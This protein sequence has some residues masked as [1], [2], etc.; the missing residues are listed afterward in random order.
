MAARKKPGVPNATSGD[1]DS[2]VSS[3][4]RLHRQTQDFA[5]KAVNVALTLRNWLIG[6]RI[7]EHELHGSDWAAYGDNARSDA[8]VLVLAE[9]SFR[10]VEAQALALDI[11]LKQQDYGQSIRIL[12]AVLRTNEKNH[13]AQDSR[14]THRQ[15]ISTTAGR[16]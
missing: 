4:V 14:S 11:S 3:I 13:Q 9:R 7:A 2:L 1:F 5:T 12:D 8:L 16:H 15:R 10:D 6:C